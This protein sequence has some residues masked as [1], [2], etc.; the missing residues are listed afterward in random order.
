MARKEEI[1]I[2]VY[3]FTGFLDSGKTS[4]IQKTLEDKRFNAGE[5]TLLLVCEEGEEEYDFPSFAS[6]NVTKVVVDELEDLTEQN[7]VNWLKQSKAERVMVEYNGMWMLDDL[8]AAFPENWV[9]AQELTFAEASTFPSYNAN[10]RNL[11]Y[12][13]LK[14][15]EVVLFN[16]LDGNTDVNQ[17]HKIIR[18]S[19]RRCNIAYEYKDGHSE[20]DQIED[21][22][23]YDMKAETV[24]I[25]DRDFAYFFSDMMDNMPNYHGKKFEFLAQCASDD[26]LPKGTFVGGRQIMNCCAADTQFAGM[27]GYWKDARSFGDGVWLRLTGTIK[28]ENNA[29]YDGQGP[30]LYVTSIKPEKTPEDPVATFY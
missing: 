15:C 27:L 26:N 4:F 25:E 19:N 14:S 3:L 28:I 16:R 18:Q 20:P 8:Y 7:L 6:G 29:L 12:D 23:P 22:L 11:V 21:P 10:M 1:Q 2:P 13:K 5:A 24:K 30:V 9:V 17:L